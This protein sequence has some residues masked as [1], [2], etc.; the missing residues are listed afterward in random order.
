MNS[1]NQL[2]TP[3]IAWM[4]FSGEKEVYR[5][6]SFS[7]VFKAAQVVKDKERTFVLSGSS[8]ESDHDAGA[9]KWHAIPG[10]NHLEEALSRFAVS[11]LNVLNRNQ[12]R[13]P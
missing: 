3:V 5:T 7:D 4:S 11:L 6:E 13:L 10:L 2:L 12:H 8:S 1:S 9:A